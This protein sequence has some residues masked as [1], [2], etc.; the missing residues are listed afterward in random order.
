MHDFSGTKL[1]LLIGDRLATIL[2]DDIKGLPWPG[3]WDLPG[4]GREGA[5]SPAQCV[6]RETRE[7][8]GLDLRP[9]DLI[10][11]KPVPSRSHPGQESWFF[12]AHLPAGAARGI[13]LGDEGQEWRLV[14]PQWFID[15]PKAV[16]HFRPVVREAVAA[17]GL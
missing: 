8:L 14:A 10:W 2:R 5:E 13:V 11:K 7:E 17:L 16:T 1:V 15:N 3:Y 6:L 9:A 12:A 4:G